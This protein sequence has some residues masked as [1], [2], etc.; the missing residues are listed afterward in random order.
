MHVKVD[1]TSLVATAIAVSSTVSLAQAP[2]TA[3]LVHKATTSIPP[4]SPAIP[5]QLAALAATN[6]P[7]L[8]VLLAA[9]DTSSQTMPANLYHATFQIAYTAQLPIV[10]SSVRRTTTGTV[11]YA[12]QEGVFHAR[13]EQMVRYRIIA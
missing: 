10:A 13:W 5:A 7:L 3:Q 9:K 6:S 1:I 8:P 4:S 12:F 11:R 2:M